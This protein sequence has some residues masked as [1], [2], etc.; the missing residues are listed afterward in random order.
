MNDQRSLSGF[1]LHFLAKCECSKALMRD[2][3]GLVA[4]TWMRSLS[5]LYLINALEV[6]IDE[7]LFLKMKLCSIST[8]LLKGVL[9]VK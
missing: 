2:N 4:A 5:P 8:I 1:F 7:Q 6:A 9:L 3:A